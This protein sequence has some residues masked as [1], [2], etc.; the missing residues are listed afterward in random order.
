MRTRSGLDWTGKFAAITD[1]GSGFPNC[2]IDGDVVALDRNGIPDFAALQVALSD[3]R[4][5]DL[6]YFVF[7][8][9]FEGAKD[10]RRMPLTTRKDR[11]VKLLSH[12]GTHARHFKYVE[13]FT[14]LGEAVLKSACKLNL[15]G[16]I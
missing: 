1:A 6:T 2:I 7:D 10:L 5:Q 12:K 14:E 3:G 8:L 4:S 11:L 15:E 9:L 13:H 16:I